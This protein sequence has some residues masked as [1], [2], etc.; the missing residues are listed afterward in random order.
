MIHLAVKIIKVFVTQKIVIND[1]PLP[2]GVVER[3]SVTFA[4]EV[5]PLVEVQTKIQKFK[6]ICLPQDAQTHCLRN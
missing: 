6:F 1:I 4:G 2:T 5:K 3:V